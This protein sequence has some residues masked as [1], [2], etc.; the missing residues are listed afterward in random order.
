MPSL[1]NL[2]STET[3]TSTTLGPISNVTYAY[4]NGPMF[5]N[6]SQRFALFLC[7][8]IIGIGACL[9]LTLA[10]IRDHRIRQENNTTYETRNT[11]P[12]YAENDDVGRAKERFKR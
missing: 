7:C 4:N 1:P 2:N 6:D 9:Y 12:G 3:V 10:A 8:T 11:L 5:Q